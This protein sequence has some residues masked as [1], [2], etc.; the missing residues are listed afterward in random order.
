MEKT[1]PYSEREAEK[2]IFNSLIE[3]ERILSNPDDTLLRNYVADFR[4]KDPSEVVKVEYLKPGAFLRY[5]MI[6]ARTGSPL[7]QYKPPK[8]IPS[9]RMD[10]YETLTN[11]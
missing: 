3:E 6:K 5:A 2:I 8:I 1:W 4:I 7:G 9:D 11:A 10:I